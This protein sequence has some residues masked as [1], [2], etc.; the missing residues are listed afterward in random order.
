VAPLFAKLLANSGV[1]FRQARVTR[2]VPDCPLA[3]AGGGSL[4]GGAVELAC[5]GVLPYDYLVVALGA[6]PA[7]EGVAG[8]REYALPFASYEDYC[9][10]RTALDVAG[11][12]RGTLPVR[13]AIVGGGL[14]GT[15]LA[16]A[17]C[18]RLRGNCEA[19]LL[20]AGPLLL[21]DAASG[22]RAAAAAALAAAGVRVLTRRR[23]AAVAAGGTTTHAPLCVM[24]L[25]QNGGAEGGGG[26]EPP[27]PLP[28]D[29]V[30][31]AAGQRRAGG[32][33]LSPLG[34]VEA[35][36]T[37]RLRG[38]ER[39][40]AVG[41]VAAAAAAGGAPLPATAQVAFQQADYA[42]WNVWALD[43]R[44]PMLPFR[45]QHLGEMMS[46]GADGAAVQLPPL[47][48]G[49]PAEG[50]TLGGPLAALL[51]RAAYVYR[52]PTDGQRA[53]VGLSWLQRGW[54]ELQSAFVRGAG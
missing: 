37:L 10:L 53:T 45:Y 22:Q 20:V 52:M 15:E 34:P 17:L 21:D 46:L 29:V 1:S 5:G 3:V 35:D 16:A 18:S 11:A 12:R 49:G 14:A 27:P 33:A 9:A 4:G 13:V 47:P 38:H 28:A 7:P 36:S 6:E 51:R 54:A 8:A 2:V 39:V 24:F 30:L 19:T 40:F 50:V 31:W 42:A 25:P 23:V 26:R 32:L 41:D 43:T 44:R 48:W